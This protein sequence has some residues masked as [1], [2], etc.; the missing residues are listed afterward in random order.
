M[1]FSQIDV[2]CCVRI[3]FLSKRN[4]VLLTFPNAKWMEKKKHE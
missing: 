3:S 4:K 1:Y 2:P